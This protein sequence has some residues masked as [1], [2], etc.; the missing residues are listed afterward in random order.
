VLRVESLTKTYAHRH[1]VDGVSLIV[2]RGEIVVLAGPNGSGKTTTIECIAGLRRATSGRILVAGC[3]V[4]RSISY[5]GHY[6]LQLQESSFPPSGRVIEVL[7]VIA[8]LYRNPIAPVDLLQRV[9]LA[10]V[11]RSPYENLS[12]G[13]KR[14]LNV[15]VAFIGRPPLV[16]LDEPTSG[17]DPQGRVALWDFVREVAR[18]GTAILLTTHDLTEAEDYADRL[19][20]LKHGRIALSGSV[21]DLLDR[22][23]STWRL[24]ATV[25]PDQIDLI[26]VAGLR[27]VVID[28]VVTAFGDRA[29]VMRARTQLESSDNGCEDLLVGPTRLEDLFLL[30]TMGER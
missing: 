1:A 6:G 10:D 18:C 28:G 22:N 24:R 26:D 30:E 14:R 8:S 11:S 7:Q 12:G 20:A 15:A 5:R 17:V 29:Q 23:G 16:M 13:E 25:S 21:Q 4:D 27:V 2:D 19:I 9:G 3:P